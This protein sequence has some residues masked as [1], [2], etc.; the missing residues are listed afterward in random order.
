AA[1]A[2]LA[3]TV[4]ATPA[5]AAG[6]AGAE[7][8]A[9]AADA[10]R[11]GPHPPVLLGERL[12]RPAES[13]P[14]ALAGRAALLVAVQFRGRVRDEWRAALEATGA[15]IAG[16]LPENAYLVRAAGAAR[17]R[18]DAYV[19]GAPEVAGTVR[20]RRA[21]K[22]APGLPATGRVLVSVQTVDGDRLTRTIDAAALDE[23]AADSD[24]VSVTPTARPELLDERQGVIVA[25]GALAAPGYLAALDRV[26][27]DPLHPF[28]FAIDISD[29]ALDTGADPP[30]HPAFFVGGDPAAADRLAYV[31]KLTGPDDP[32]QG[33]G[34][35]GTLNASVAA[36]AGGDADSDGYSEML[37]I[38]PGALIGGSTIFRCDGLFGLSSDAQLVEMARAAHAD[39]ARIANASW[40]ADTSVDGSGN[41]VGPGAAYDDLAALFDG[42]VRDARPDVPGNQ[43]LAYVVAAGND[44]AAGGGTITTPATAK[45]VISVGASES[46]RSL[47]PSLWCGPADSDDGAN[48]PQQVAPF[49]SRGPTADGRIKPDLVAPGTHVL[50]ARSQIGTPPW[51]GDG[52]CGVLGPFS[53]ASSGTSHAA[54]V[55]AGL[56]AVAR[57]ALTRTG[58]PPPSPAMLK[59][60][61]VGG[62]QRL[63][64]ADAGA[65]PG[66][67]QGW[68]L[69]R[70][71][72]ADPRGRW[73]RDQRDVLGETGASVS[74]RMAPRDPA[75]PV[76]LTLAWTDPPPLSL[77]AASPLVNDLD[78]EVETPTGSIY[79]GNVPAPGGL[80]P[81]GGTADRLNNLETIVLPPGIGPVTVRVRAANLPGDGIP[82]VGDATD[83][84]FALVVAGADELPAEP[85]AEP[86]PP[87]SEEPAPAAPS[88]TS[89]R[90]LHVRGLPSRRRCVRSRSLRLRIVAPPG[91]HLSSAVVRAGRRRA[92]R[93]RGRGA[94]TS[95]VVRV[96]SLPRGRWT[97][98]I[99][100]RTSEG[101]PLRRS[102]SFRSCPRQR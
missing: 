33:C 31:H 8:A 24:V 89:A 94:R 100:A 78:L 30:S 41:P 27:P 58:A 3:A 75:A 99:L 92:L 98:R 72:G 73:L 12:A 18:L 1:V 20:L 28:D 23:L 25:A 68:G 60:M 91:E 2:A 6:A 43:E 71:R 54:P 53:V 74:W 88:T 62:G 81:P 21:D 63:P 102:I 67:A 9:R 38:A 83:Q 17:E 101:E 56:A 47:D 77:A 14:G 26:V 36:G 42:L 15:Q 34:G 57:R 35:H 37:G 96:R 55:V 64:A 22:L 70:L 80:T 59:A 79:R 45:N 46:V 51:T 19:A 44:G 66:P 4:G 82:G 40:G 49:S 50:G 97:L 39:G 32:P 76:T 10:A 95:A 87:V 11:H 7:G 48:D 65:W 86:P 85:P 52:V 84:D 69:A 29:D 61:L 5:N 90:T 93:V 13:P 16:Y